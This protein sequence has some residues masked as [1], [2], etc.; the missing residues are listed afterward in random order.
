MALD[1]PA[2]AR[3]AHE[4]AGEAGDVITRGQR[5]IH[6]LLRRLGMIQEDS[7]MS[8]LETPVASTQGTLPGAAGERGNLSV[9]WRIGEDH[10]QRRREDPR[11]I[12][13]RR[14][15]AASKETRE[16]QPVR[17]MTWQLSCII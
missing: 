6:K 16:G 11:M 5:Q 2:K 14:R 4:L 10:K 17:K 3:E 7:K 15:R 9:G 13:R 8:S 1:N 12:G